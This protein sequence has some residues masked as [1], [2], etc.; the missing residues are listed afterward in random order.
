MKLYDFETSSF[1]N[2]ITYYKMVSEDFSAQLQ[3][4][5]WKNIMVLGIKTFG[6]VTTG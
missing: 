6:R 3:Q 5:P 1:W 4:G 2:G